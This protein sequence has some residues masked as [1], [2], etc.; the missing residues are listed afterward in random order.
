MIIN[1]SK[2]KYMVI[3]GGVRDRM[4]IKISGRMIDHFDQYVDLGCIFTSDGSTKSSLCAQFVGRQKHYNKLVL[5]LRNICDMPTVMKKKVI[6]AAFNAALLY[7]CE[8]WLDTYL[9]D[10]EKLYIGA[11]KNLLAA[12]VTTPSD[13][14]LI[15]LGYPSAGWYQTGGIWLMIHLCSRLI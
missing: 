10:V 1:E 15:E 14:C 9:K 7:G 5:F 3:H 2:T 11:I 13:L 12:R 4:P 8:S 6:D